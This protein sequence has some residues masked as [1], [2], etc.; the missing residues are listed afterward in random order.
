M[1]ALEVSNPPTADD[2]AQIAERVPD[3][4][5]YPLR[6]EPLLGGLTNLNY[7]IHGAPEEYVLRVTGEAD[8]LCPE[9]EPAT[10][11][12]SPA[13]PHAARADC[14]RSTSALDSHCQRAIC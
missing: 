11:V 1:D 7:R 10:R 6:A 5:G 12:S 9:S 3:L 8:E 14:A 13:S 2:L 4:R